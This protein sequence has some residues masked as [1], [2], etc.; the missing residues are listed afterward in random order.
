[1]HAAGLPGRQAAQAFR[2]IYDY[3]FGFAL[4]DPA[5][6]TEQRLR[7]DSNSNHSSAPCLT[8]VSPPW[9]RTASTPGPTT[10]SSASPSVSTL[11]SAACRPK[12]RDYEMRKLTVTWAN[13]TRGKLAF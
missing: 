1:M 3:T 4:A 13:D 2:L 11:S 12:L 9:P 6:P 8:A 5:S 7:P 10:A